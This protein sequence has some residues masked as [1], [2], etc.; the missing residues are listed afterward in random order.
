MHYYTFNIGDYRGATA[1]LSNEEDLAY[2]R[3]LDMYYD[4]EKK[5]PV[6]SQWV[7]RRLR[8]DTKVIEMF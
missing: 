2:R 1:H 4:T 5:I 8:L 7:A 6:D 3:L